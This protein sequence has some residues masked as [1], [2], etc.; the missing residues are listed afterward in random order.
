MSELSMV[1]GTGH[2]WFP[3]EGDLVRDTESGRYGV[4]LEVRQ[5]AN[6]P[7]DAQ[8]A[9][10]DD[11]RAWS[12]VEVNAEQL[13][14]DTRNDVEVPSLREITMEFGEAASRVLGD[15]QLLAQLR[16]RVATD[17]EL[18]GVLEIEATRCLRV[19]DAAIAVH[20]YDIAARERER[21]SSLRWLAAAVRT[22][23]ERTGYRP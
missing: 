16:A 1:D 20:R 17:D 10:T 22:V 23:I 6:A 8:V 7:A 3:R 14:R 15:V 11:G 19:G 5:T 21:A 12:V 9:L 2:R 18:V 4:V 13:E